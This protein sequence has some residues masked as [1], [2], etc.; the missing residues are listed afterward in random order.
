MES[1]LLEAIKSVLQP[2]DIPNLK[3][4]E[5]IYLAITDKV[6][7]AELALRLNQQSFILPSTELT[8]VVKW[9]YD[10]V[11]V[12][13]HLLDKPLLDHWGIDGWELVAVYNGLAYF[14]RCVP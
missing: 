7:Y 1:P 3:W 4:A 2:L 12:K 8:S 13:G 11:Q 5:K 14:K 6:F 9:E 10:A